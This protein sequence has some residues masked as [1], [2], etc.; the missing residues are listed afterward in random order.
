MIKEKIDGDFKMYRIEWLS[1]S[2]WR[3]AS[4]CNSEQQAMMQVDSL[5]SRNINKKYRIKNPEGTVI[6]TS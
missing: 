4:G 5:S 6:Y 2:Q 1:G 3:F